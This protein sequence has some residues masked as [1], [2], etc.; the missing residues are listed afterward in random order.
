MK[1]PETASAVWVAIGVLLGIGMDNV[2]AGIAIGV[3][4][5]VAMYTTG[6]KSEKKIRVINKMIK[7]QNRSFLF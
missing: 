3:A 6:R 2:G 4:I 1:N 5:G 7:I